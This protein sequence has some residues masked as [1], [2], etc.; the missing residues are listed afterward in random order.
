M[1]DVTSASLRKRNLPRLMF[2]HHH[3]CNGPDVSADL[4][5]MWWNTIIK[6]YSWLW[7][8]HGDESSTSDGGDNLMTVVVMM[9]KAV[10]MEMIIVIET[11]M[12]HGG[13]D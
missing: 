8:L 6:K 9:T 10:I 4:V 3:L 12:V 13:D 7:S 11:M 1:I 5:H 2:H